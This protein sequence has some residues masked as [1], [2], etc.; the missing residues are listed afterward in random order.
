MKVKTQHVPEDC[1][2]LTNGKE[3]EA[4]DGWENA[5]NRDLFNIKD[6]NGEE[7]IIN[8]YGCGHLDGKA[9]EVVED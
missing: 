2:Y 8:L 7:A 6:D 3:Y 5:F 1:D 9:W 4:F